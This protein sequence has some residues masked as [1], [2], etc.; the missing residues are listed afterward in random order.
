[1][2]DLFSCPEVPAFVNTIQDGG[3]GKYIV[4][5]DGKDFTTE[6]IVDDDIVDEGDS[7]QLIKGSKPQLI[8]WGFLIFLLLV[9]VPSIIA[10]FT[11]NLKLKR[12]R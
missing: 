7:A 6:K 11:S 2:G 3:V 5:Y 1:M 10:F 4:N 9:L 8:S 12:K